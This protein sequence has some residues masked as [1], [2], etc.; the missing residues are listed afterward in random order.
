MEHLPA[1]LAGRRFHGAAGADRAPVDG[2]EIHVHP[3]ALEQVGGDVAL[4]LGDR[5]VLGD[6][7]GDRLARIAALLQQFLRAIEI[8]RALEDLAAFLG[9]ERR[10]RGEEARERFPQTVVVADD[11]PHVVFLAH[12]HQN[13]A[14][15]PHLVERWVEVVHAEAADISPFCSAAAAVAGSGITTHST[16]SASIRLPPASHEAG[17]ERG[18]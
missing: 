10:T 5:L 6:Q 17:S 9:V 15:R 12:R 2:G 16:R 14:P 4:R 7:A 18:V 3:E 13:R 8:A 1:A 11:G